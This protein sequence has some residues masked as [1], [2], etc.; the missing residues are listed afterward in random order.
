MALGLYIPRPGDVL[1]CDYSTGFVVPEM[2]KH[3]PV[4][5]ISGRERH[6]RGLCTVVPLSTTDPVP[7]EAWHHCLDVSIPG[8][9]TA[10][11]WAKCDMLSTVAF[12]R[13]TK[14]HTKTRAAGREYHTV[15]LAPLDL[16]AVRNAVLRYLH[17]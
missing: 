2:V 3:R 10:R 11:C 5:V 17:F 8:W 4:V 15:R 14:P 12:A 7:P 9:A 13:L 1:I 6:A 16:A